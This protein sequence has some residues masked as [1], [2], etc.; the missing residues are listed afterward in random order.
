VRYT[1]LFFTIIHLVT[2]TSLS[3]QLWVVQT[4]NMSIYVEAIL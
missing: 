1:H 3:P 2:L 4:A